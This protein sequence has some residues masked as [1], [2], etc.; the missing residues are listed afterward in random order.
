MYFFYMN[1]NT[2]VLLVRPPAIPRVDH[3]RSPVLRALGDFAIPFLTKC[4][5]G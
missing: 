1:L 4:M 5:F 2:G 3:H